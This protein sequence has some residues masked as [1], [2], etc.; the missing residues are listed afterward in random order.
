MLFRSGLQAYRDAF[1]GSCHRFGQYGQGGFGPDL[2]TVRQRFSREDLVDA[3]VYPSK[4]ISDFW[5]AVEVTT[6]DGQS[7]IGT[8]TNEGPNSVTLATQTQQRI[9]I[10][11]SDIES[12]SR[13]ST[14][15][16][17]D[18]LLHNLSRQEMIDLILFLEEGPQAAK[19]S[20]GASDAETGD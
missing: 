11:K 9:T 3:I 20:D 13:A 10:D 12:R 8:V 16:M 14:S 2:T 17:P 6:N 19:K 15:P 18:Y 7:Y 1:C 5:A 4:T